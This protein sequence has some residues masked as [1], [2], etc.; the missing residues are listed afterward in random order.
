MERDPSCSGPKCPSEPEASSGSCSWLAEPK[1]VGHLLTLFQGL[2]QGAGLKAEQLGQK[3][4]SKGDSASIEDCGF[5]CYSTLCLLPQAVE[6][7]YLFVK[8]LLAG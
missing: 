8:D 2:Y 6:S 5:T 7:C 1:Q 4:A 3:L